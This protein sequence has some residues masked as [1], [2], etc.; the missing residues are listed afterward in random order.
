VACDPKFVSGEIPSA[1]VELTTAKVLAVHSTAFNWQKEPETGTPLVVENRCGKGTA[2]LLTA[3]CYP[4][5]P[6]VKGL[7]GELFRSL[8]R[9]EQGAIKVASTD[10]IRYAVYEEDGRR[11]VYLLNTDTSFPQAADVHA[12]S[13]K[14]VR[15]E[16][17]PATLRWVDVADGRVMTKQGA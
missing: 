1:T 14:P 16:I 8:L 9:A 17:P 12:D 15:V 10:K 4:G 7:Y 13:A 3:A 5:H 6:G 11:R 2:W